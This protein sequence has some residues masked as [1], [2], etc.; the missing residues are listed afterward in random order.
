MKS[1]RML[2]PKSLYGKGSKFGVGKSFFYENYVL[3]EGGDVFI[4]GT[5]LFRLRLVN[6]GKRAVAA[7]EDEADELIEGL[8]AQRDAAPNKQRE[9]A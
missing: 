9:T 6:L 7:F 2:R 4:P 5:K 1:T 8:R 3:R